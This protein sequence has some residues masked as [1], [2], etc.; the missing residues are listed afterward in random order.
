L[1]EGQAGEIPSFKQ[2]FRKPCIDVIGGR[3]VYSSFILGIRVSGDVTQEVTQEGEQ[4]KPVDITGLEQMSLV[5]AGTGLVGADIEPVDGNVGAIRRVIDGVAV[6][7]R[8]IER[9]RPFGAPAQK[10]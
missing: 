4:R 6:G 5:E 3:P 10:L 9:Q 1:E 2:Y 8:E 7:L